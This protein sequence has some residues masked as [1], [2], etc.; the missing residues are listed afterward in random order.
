MDDSESESEEF[1][2]RDGYIHYGATIKLVCTR[3]GIAL[4]RLVSLT[5]PSPHILVSQIIGLLL[6]YS[7]MH[8]SY[9][10]SNVCS[11]QRQYA[12]DSG[13]KLR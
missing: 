1:V 11:F 10:I 8:V 12:K 4:P 6:L 7:Q 5:N 3:T 9:L 13:I 2:V